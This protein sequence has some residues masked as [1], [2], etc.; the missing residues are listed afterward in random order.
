LSSASCLLMSVFLNRVST[1]RVVRIFQV[2]S[3]ATFYELCGRNLL[4]TNAVLSLINVLFSQNYF[5]VHSLLCCTVLVFTASGKDAQAM[6]S[7]AHSSVLYFN[8]FKSDRYLPI[9]ILS[10]CFSMCLAISEINLC[11]D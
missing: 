8:S 2:E 3:G 5:S 9:W 10:M 7:F 4:I 1:N 6:G 11:R